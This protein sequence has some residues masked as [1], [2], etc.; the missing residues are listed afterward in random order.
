[1]IWKRNVVAGVEEW[2]TVVVHFVI[3]E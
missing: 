1:L 3:G 2:A